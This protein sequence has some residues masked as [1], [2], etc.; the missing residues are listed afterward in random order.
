MIMMFIWVVFLIL[1]SHQTLSGGQHLFAFDLDCSCFLVSQ[2]G[3][4]KVR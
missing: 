1:R 2:N 4:A 3:R